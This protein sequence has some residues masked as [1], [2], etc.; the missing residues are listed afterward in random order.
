M[1]V[2]EPASPAATRYACRS[3]EARVSGRK[4]NWET[5]NRASTAPAQVPGV[6]YMTGYFTT[7]ANKKPGTPEAG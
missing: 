7:A 6:G 4:D 5:K 3:F 2:A 1:A